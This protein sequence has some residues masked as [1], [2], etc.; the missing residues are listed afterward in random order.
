MLTNDRLNHLKFGNPNR[1][2][3]IYLETESYLDSL[4][5]ELTSYPFPDNYGQDSSEEILNLIKYTNQLAQEEELLKRCILYDNDFE[6]Y[7]IKVL[8]EKG[9]PE[10]DVKS[11]VVDIHKDIHP[12]L[13]KLKYYYNRPRPQQLALYKQLPLYVWKSRTS[14]TPAYPSGHCFQSI[15]YA[16]VLGS[17]YPKY[18]K[19]LAALAD[20]ISLSREF[21]GVHYVSDTK[22]AQYCAGLVL[23]HPEFV[24][25]YK[26]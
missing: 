12:L 1:Q 6:I 11:I 21:M 16:E 8:S 7:I 14:D 26:L 22:F 15:V 9:I 18:Y 25:K 4:L 17:K 19:A 2:H 3:L 5:K 13:L 24:K 23:K 10:E 20:D